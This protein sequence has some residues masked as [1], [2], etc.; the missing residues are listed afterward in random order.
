MVAPML[1]DKELFSCHGTNYSLALYKSKIV[2][3]GI[4]WRD[5]KSYEF[6]ITRL[7]MLFIQRKSVVPFASFTLLS[8]IVALI[9]R[10]NALRFLV[11]LAPEYRALLSIG[12]ILV[13]VLSAIPLMARG[14]FVNVLVGLDEEPTSYK[15]RFVPGRSGKRLVRRFEE[16]SQGS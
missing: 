4:S 7:K 10:Y 16:I 9:A 15:I 12:A 14:L 5:Q 3:K 2:I 8:A 13:S 1:Q 11:D 6:P